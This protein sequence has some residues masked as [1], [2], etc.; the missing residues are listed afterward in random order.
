VGSL[1]AGRR[2]HSDFFVRWRLYRRGVEEFLSDDYDYDPSKST[3]FNS[4]FCVPVAGSR[5]GMKRL[6]KFFR[7]L[8]LLLQSAAVC[9]VGGLGAYLLWSS[10]VDHQ[11]FRVNKYLALAPLQGAQY[12]L[13]A[14][15][16]ALLI[17]PI[18]WVV[19]NLLMAAYRLTRRRSGKATG[20]A[21]VATGATKPGA[22]GS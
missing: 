12:D 9:T 10:K 11:D 19:G 7:L 17:R 1:S 13:A 20:T 2:V 6:Y 4:L 18:R 21:R 16:L 3:L 5:I 14:I 8:P 22:T 15:T